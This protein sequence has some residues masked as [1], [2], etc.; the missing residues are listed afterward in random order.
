VR[1]EGCGVENSEKD[2]DDEVFAND[3]G[4]V[5]ESVTKGTSCG[6]RDGL[7]MDEDGFLGDG[8]DARV[9]ENRYIRDDI[10]MKTDQSILELNK[11]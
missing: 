3:D 11:T 8:S 5:D 1:G 7:R 9:S 4:K 6:E 10:M 2:D